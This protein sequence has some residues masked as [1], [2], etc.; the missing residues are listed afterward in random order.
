MPEKEWDKYERN[1]C[2]NINGA[3][4]DH[5]FEANIWQLKLEDQVEYLKSIAIAG[6]NMGEP[7][8]NKFTEWIYWKL[9]NKIAKNYMIP[10]NQKMFSNLLVRK[11]TKCKF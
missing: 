1:T 5:P 10:Y 7:K 2:I 11:I 3:F 9:G 8:P 4:I 6:C